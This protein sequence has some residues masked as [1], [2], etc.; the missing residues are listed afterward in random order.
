MHLLNCN[1]HNPGAAPK[2]QNRPLLWEPHAETQ[3]MADEVAPKVPVM[4]LENIYHTWTKLKIL[5]PEVS[6]LFSDGARAASVSRIRGADVFLIHSPKEFGFSCF[7]TAWMITSSAALITQRCSFLPSVPKISWL[8]TLSWEAIT[9]EFSST[10]QEGHL[11]PLCNP[12]CWACVWCVHLDGVCIGMVCLCVSDGRVNRRK[13]LQQVSGCW[14]M[15]HQT[16]MW[17]GEGKR[18]GFLV[19]CH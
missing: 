9:A 12:S 8:I 3:F 7:R 14:S 11:W 19:S 1:P 18:S 2:P 13:G 16:V 5:H 4:S 6:D 15:V 10:L 17:E